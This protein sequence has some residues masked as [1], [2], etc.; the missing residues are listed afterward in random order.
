MEHFPKFQT[1][2]LGAAKLGVF[3]GFMNEGDLHLGFAI[4]SRPNVPQ[5]FVSVTSGLPAFGV[6]GTIAAGLFPKP[7]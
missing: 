1:R 6:V 4:A 2:G 5:A 7:Q 3:Y